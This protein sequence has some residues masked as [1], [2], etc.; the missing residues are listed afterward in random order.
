[1]LEI[2]KHSHLE[3]IHSTAFVFVFKWDDVQNTDIK[4]VQTLGSYILQLFDHSLIT[5]HA[6]LLLLV[7]MAI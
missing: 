4:Y 5:N 6:W 2:F 7:V 3:N 1:M